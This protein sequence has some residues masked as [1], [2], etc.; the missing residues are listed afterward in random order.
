MSRCPEMSNKRPSFEAR[1]ALRLLEI[2]VPAETERR[3]L[4]AANG[5]VRAYLLGECSILVTKEYGRWHFSIAH[6][7]RYPTWDEV[8]EARYRLLPAGL[9]AAMILP[10]KGEYINMHE[11]CFQVIEVRDP[12]L[13]Q[14]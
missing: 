8:A 14:L 10:P 13:A 6:P 9:H 1:K 2:P 4:N 7:R 5:Y 3:L 11:F 12:I